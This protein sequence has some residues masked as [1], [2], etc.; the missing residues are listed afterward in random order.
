MALSP[1]F[2]RLKLAA[3]AG[4][5]FHSALESPLF[6]RVLGFPRKFLGA[7]TREARQKH[8]RIGG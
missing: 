3:Q 1:G 5:Q 8:K 7:K 2:V 6:R 4:P